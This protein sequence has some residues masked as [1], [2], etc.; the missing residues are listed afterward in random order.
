MRKSPYTYLPVTESEQGVTV[1]CVQLIPEKTG[2]VEQVQNC[3][4]CPQFV[5]AYKGLD[6][7]VRVTCS[8]P[9]IACGK[10]KGR[11]GHSYEEAPTNHA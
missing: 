9:R 11:T 1:P 6:G 2:L 8:W 10:K 4:M 7:K 3:I 5:E